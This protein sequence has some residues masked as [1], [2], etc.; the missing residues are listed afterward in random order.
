MKI[1]VYNCICLA[2]EFNLKSIVLLRSSLFILGVFCTLMPGKAQS[3]NLPIEKW[4]KELSVKRDLRAEKFYAVASELNKLTLDVYCRVLTTFKERIPSENKRYRI[5]ILNLEVWMNGAY[6]KHCAGGKTNFELLQEALPLAYEIEDEFLQYQIHTQLCSNYALQNKYGQSI[7]HGLM[8]DELFEKLGSENL[9]S[10]SG[11][12]YNLSFGYFHSREYRDCINTSY[13]VLESYNRD[14]SNPED[15]ALLIFKM[16][17]WN[18]MG[19][20]Y[21]KIDE[22]D[23]AFIAFDSA[24]VM[25]GKLHDEFW[26]GIIIGNKGDVYFKME[27]Y[28]SAEVMLSLDYEQSLVSNQ[29]DNAANS[30]QWLARIDLHYGRATEALRKAREAEDLLHKSYHPVYMANTLYTFTK[31]FGSLGKADSV[32]YYLEKFLVLHDSIEQKASDSRTENVLMRLDNQEY[33]H[34][35]INLNKEKK[36]VALIR[37]FI[38][39]LII[40]LA[41]VVVMILN[42]RTLKHK[43]RSKE[44]LDARRAAE[45]DALLAKEQ[46]TQFTRNLREKTALVET[47]QSQLLEREVNEDQM[48]RIS[49]LSH[50]AILTDEDW[51]SF[52]ALFEK[53]YPGFFYTLKEKSNDLTTADLRMAAL[54]RLQVSNKDAASLLGIAPNSVIKAR[55]R[56]RH[57]LGLEPEADLELYFSQAK[58]FNEE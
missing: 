21:H 25:A 18:T 40:L 46:L 55:Q 39:I 51:D 8:A 30:L 27:R 6:L 57:R 37:N 43:M 45:Q 16:F 41:L 5:N 32:S 26:K 7:L 31:V 9:P 22:L 3:S 20:A 14:L 44:A 10:H 34:T 35:I 17:C 52:K 54:C 4:V 19:L 33:V 2:M 56:L 13:K 58:E 47:L 28:D 11:N 29:L 24:Y 42:R 15:S 50:H 38:L 36:R 48:A 23:S 12:L 53:V 49:E 1:K